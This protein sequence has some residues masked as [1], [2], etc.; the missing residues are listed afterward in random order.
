MLM[1]STKVQIRNILINHP[2]F[3][4]YSKKFLQIS[5]EDD[6]DHCWLLGKV[7]LRVQSTRSSKNSHESAKCIITFQDKKKIGE[8][9][10]IKGI[11]DTLHRFLF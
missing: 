9:N 3:R 2:A 5:L 8:S 6:R 10:N 11:A 1:S 4:D 7:F